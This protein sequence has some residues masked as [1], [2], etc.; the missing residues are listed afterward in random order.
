MSMKFSDEK[1]IRKIWR[2][3]QLYA[4]F[5]H[6]GYGISDHWEII[7]CIFICNTMPSGPLLYY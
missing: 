7:Q 3:I 6:L 1:K 5:V 4:L 2:G